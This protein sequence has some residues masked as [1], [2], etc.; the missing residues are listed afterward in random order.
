MSVCNQQRLLSYYYPSIAGR[1]MKVRDM[2]ASISADLKVRQR[3]LLPEGLRRE[4]ASRAGADKLTRVSGNSK[5]AIPAQQKTK[6][7][8]GSSKQQ[9][10]FICKKYQKR[11][12]WATGA[13]KRCGTCLC[14]DRKYPNRP[15]TCHQEHITSSDPNIICNGVKKVMFPRES[16]HEGW[17]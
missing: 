9:T 6:R 16:R 8:T 3:R 10:C 4:I 2:A 11:Y 15:L 1:D 13:C 17:S 12:V 5:K 14:L 7:S